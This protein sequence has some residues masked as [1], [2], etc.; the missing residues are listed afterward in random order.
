MSYLE[1]A[2][3][4]VYILVL[5]AGT[6]FAIVG[7]PGTALIAVAAL[8]CAL[9]TWFH[10]PGIGT[11]IALVIT[12]ILVEAGDVGLRIIG[13]R[14]LSVSVRSV[15]A[16]VTGSLLGFAAVSAALGGPGAFIG[17]ALGGC[18]GLFAVHL[19]GELKRKPHLRMSAAALIAS[20]ATVLVKGLIAAVM[21]FVALMALYF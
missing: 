19:A 21:S 16:A 3:S 4:A 15:G 18:V 17:I 5:C 20:T 2:A 1:A 12:A 8:L 7:L 14:P 11:V 10:A 6:F 13:V 9:V